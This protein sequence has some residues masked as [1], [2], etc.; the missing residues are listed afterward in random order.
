MG[1]EEGEEERISL[2]KVRKRISVR[3]RKGSVCV[4]CCCDC[5]GEDKEEGLYTAY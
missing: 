5:G 4:R 1:R 3:K 2:R